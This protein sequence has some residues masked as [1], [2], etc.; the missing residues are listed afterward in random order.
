M[1]TCSEQYKAGKGEGAWIML[2]NYERNWKKL[3][4]FYAGWMRLVVVKKIKF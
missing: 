4:D 1:K 2:K 3:S